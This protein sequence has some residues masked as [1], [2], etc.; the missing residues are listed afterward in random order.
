MK[1]VV[2]NSFFFL[3]LVPLM[4]SCSLFQQNLPTEVVSITKVI[5]QTV[6]DHEICSAF[7][8]GKEDVL[9]YFSVA[10]Q[11]NE[12]TFQH[13]AI[14]LPCKY[15]GIIKIGGD[16]LQWEIIAGG[17]GYLYNDKSINKRYLCGDKCFDALPNLR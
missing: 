1:K 5:D 15:Q 8:L 16:V 4:N 12:Y 3:L 11:V 14:I 6:V 2:I 9:T 17:A 13:E 7:T 10:E